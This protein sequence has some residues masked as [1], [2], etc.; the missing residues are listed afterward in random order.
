MTTLPIYCVKNHH[1]S[2]LLPGV[3]YSLA[4]NGS[5]STAGG[6][7]S[8]HLI[9]DGQI[10]GSGR[11]WYRIADN[12]YF[13]SS[14][15]A[16]ACGFQIDGEEI[17]NV[18]IS[19]VYPSAW[20]AKGLTIEQALEMELDAIISRH[21]ADVERAQEESVDAYFEALDIAAQD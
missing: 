10:I 15:G 19:E 7:S 11:S 4:Y 3:T 18:P 8:I 20:C 13:G 21:E 2:P 14:G 17:K 1:E 6:H 12:A 5:G 9:K 16:R